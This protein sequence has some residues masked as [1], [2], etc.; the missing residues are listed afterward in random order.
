MIHAEASACSLL[1]KRLASVRP[2]LVDVERLSRGQAATRRGIG[3]RQVPHRLNADERGAYLRAIANGFAVVRGHG[4][5]RERKGSP[6]LNTLRQRADALATPLIFVELTNQREGVVNDAT[7]VDLS[8][9]RCIEANE[10][11]EWQDRCNRVALPLSS[12]TAAHQPDITVQHAVD[13][14]ISWPIWAVAPLLLRFEASNTKTCKRL[15]S[16]LAHE[17]QTLE[18]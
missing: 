13:E 4:K 6:L 1:A 2:S 5:R 15:A 18:T 8:P 10:L 7:C 16:D 11:I 3:S 17:L 12:A 14:L 9:L